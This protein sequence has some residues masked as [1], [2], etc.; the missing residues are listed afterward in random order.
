MQELK[1]IITTVR[2]SFG[3][4]FLLAATSIR[5][6]V[7]LDVSTNYLNQ[8]WITSLLCIACL[9]G[10]LFFKASYI[11]NLTNA[12]CWRLGWCYVLSAMLFHAILFTVYTK[13]MFQDLWELYDPAQG[14]P[15]LYSLAF[16]FLA[17]RLIKLIKVRPLE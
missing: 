8:V 11:K 6:L 7:L 10:Y 13:S 15:W 2:L 5:S 4:C 12:L 14:H 17:P 1:K 16:F 3:I 9:Y